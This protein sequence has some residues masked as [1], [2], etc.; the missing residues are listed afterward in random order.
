MFEISEI[1]RLRMAWS[2]ALIDKEVLFNPAAAPVQL[3]AAPFSSYNSGRALA[4]SPFLYKGSGK[5][6]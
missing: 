6:Y 3:I 4:Q 5:R 2:I 1:L